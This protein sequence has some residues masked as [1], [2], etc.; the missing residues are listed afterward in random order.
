M[1]IEISPAGLRA[2]LDRQAARLNAEIDAKLD[3][4]CKQLMAEHGVDDASEIE[5]IIKTDPAMLDL[6]SI[7]DGCAQV[8]EAMIEVGCTPSIGDDGETVRWV[9]PKRGSR[10]LSLPPPS[11]L[12]AALPNAADADHPV[13]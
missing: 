7:P 10:P 11:P 2:M 3:A 13:H 6:S 8:L 5:E 12:L 4:R 1:K 9:A